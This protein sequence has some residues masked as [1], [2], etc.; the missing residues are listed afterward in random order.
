MILGLHA[1]AAT[2]TVGPGKTYAKPCAAIAAA[3]PGDLTEVDAAGNYAGDNCSWSTDNLTVR[4]VGGRAKIDA[5]KNEANIS[6]GKG[7]FAISAPNAT[8]ENFELVGATAGLSANGAGI[9]HQGTN[10]T[11]RDCY[12]HDNEDGILGSP[13]VDGTG[14]VLIE[15]TELA[16]NGQGDGFSHN[17]YLGKYAKFII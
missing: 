4:G 5:G 1:D 12:F 13:A 3:Q 7:I 9:R 11:V 15:G 10:L 8:V 16:N 6:A 17:M 2:R 14:T